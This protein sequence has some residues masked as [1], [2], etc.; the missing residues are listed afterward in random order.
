GSNGVYI[1]GNGDTFPSQTYAAT[2]YWVDV[3]FSQNTTTGPPQSPGGTGSP[4]GVIARRGDFSGDSE[5]DILWRNTV[6]GVVN[7]WLMNGAVLLSQGS[8]GAAT[9]DWVIAN[10]ADY[11]GDGRS[12]ILWR[13]TI[14]G[15][16][17]ERFPGGTSLIGQG[18]VGS[19]SLDW[20][21][22]K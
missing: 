22:Q 8:T 7:E 12:D 20:Q 13:D 5:A 2:N 9:A 18:S 1:Y 15:A 4:G 19:T 21:I 16:V 14:A 6:S 3:V 11:N 17:Y 10:V